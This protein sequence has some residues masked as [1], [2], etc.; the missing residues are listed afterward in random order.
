MKAVFL[1]RFQPFHRGHRKVIEDYRDEFDDFCIGIGSTDEERTEDNPLN[2]EE[3]KELIEAC[4]PDLEIV[5]IDDEE[6]TDEGNRIWM[7]K[8]KKKTGADIVISQNPLVRKIVEDFPGLELE[9]QDLHD[10]KIYSGT[11]VRRRIKSGEEWRYLVPECAEDKLGEF[12]ERI[13]DSGVQYDFE[14]GWERKNAFYDTY[15]K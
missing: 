3:R 6:K 12:V 10:P 2:F 8:V 11:A 5:G 7:E 9:E 15:E 14:P 13:K 4:Y 1:G